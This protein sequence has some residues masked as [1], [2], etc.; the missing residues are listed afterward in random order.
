MSL[1]Q[2]RIHGFLKEGTK[3]S[4]AQYAPYNNWNLIGFGPLFFFF[5]GAQ[6]HKK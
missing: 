3:L 2:W 4:G 1:W 5:E 6:I